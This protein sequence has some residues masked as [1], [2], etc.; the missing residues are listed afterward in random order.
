MSFGS[1]ML[2]IGG[3]LVLAFIATGVGYM[4][5][6]KKYNKEPKVVIQ[7][8]DR[9]DGQAR[10]CHN[11]VPK[12]QSLQVYLKTL[13]RHFTN[14]CEHRAFIFNRGRTSIPSQRRRNNPN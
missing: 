2:V 13:M 5:A 4:T 8:T 12:S 11:H 3:G 6:R 14:L 10:A 9:T 1:L 7:N